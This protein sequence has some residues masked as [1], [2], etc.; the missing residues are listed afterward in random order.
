MPHQGLVLAVE[1]TLAQ[2]P[3]CR[4][5]VDVGSEVILHC[6]QSGHSF[7]H[8]PH[9]NGSC[10]GHASTWEDEASMSPKLRKQILQPYV[11][12]MKHTFAV[13]ELSP[14]S[15]QVVLVCSPSLQSPSVTSSFESFCTAQQLPLEFLNATGGAAREWK[16]YRVMLQTLV[17]AYKT[18]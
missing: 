2:R 10:Q 12:S 3:L 18:M 5:P 14:S 11:P 13:T 9:R 16:D 7:E 15:L 8:R 1:R 4:G 17:K 6:L